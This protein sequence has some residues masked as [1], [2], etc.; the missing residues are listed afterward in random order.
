[1]KVATRFELTSH[2]GMFNMDSAFI[3]LVKESN[4]L[5]EVQVSQRN[6]QGY[7]IR[8]HFVPV[9]YCTIHASYLTFK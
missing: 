4:Q 3:N 6:F 2:E 7:G 1:M 8:S 5:N 9:Y